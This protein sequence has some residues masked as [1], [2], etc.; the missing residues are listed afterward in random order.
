MTDIRN[1]GEKSLKEVRE[2]LEAL[3]L[4]FDMKLDM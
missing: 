2:K 1:F 3:G 4:G